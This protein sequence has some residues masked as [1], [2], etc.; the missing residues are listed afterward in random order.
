M[1]QKRMITILP[2]IL[3]TLVFTQTHFTPVWSGFPLQPFAV[4]VDIA[5]VN[6]ETL[7]AGDEIGVFDGDLCVGAAIMVNEMLTT[8]S[9]FASLDNPETPESDGFTVGNPVAFRI[10]D[11]SNGLEITDPD[12]NFTAGTETFQPFGFCNVELAEIVIA[13]CTDP[14]A[15]NYNPDALVDDGSCIYEI[16]G[17]TD[18]EACN[19]DPEAN[20]DDGSCLYYDCAGECGG[21]A[22]EDDCGVCDDDPENDN[23]CLGCMDPIALNYDPASIYDDGSCD[24]PAMGDTNGDGTRNVLDIVIA[25]DVVLNPESYDFLFWMDL[26]SDSYINILDIVMLVDW[27]LYPELVG[28]TDPWAENYDPDAIYDDGSCISPTV[29]DIDGNE[30][31][32]MGIG[33]QLWMAENLKVTHYN[34]GDPIPTGHSNSQWVNLS[35]GAYAVYNNDPA[36][37]EVYGNLYNWYAVDDD[38]GICPE[39]FHVPS[40]E[41]WMELEMFLGMSYADAHDTGYWRGTDQGSQLAGNADLWSNGSLE[42]DPAFGSSGFIA[43]PGGYRDFSNGSYDDVGSH[44][45]FWSATANGSTDAWARLLYYTNTEVYRDYNYQ[46]YGFPVRCLGDN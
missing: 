32:L 5:T 36:N 31:I 41:E 25:V 19:Y 46:R 42:N 35:T 23:A 29:T 1:F 40:D 44:G 17:C 24:Y 21:S 2:V 7:Q 33:D 27:V 15:I 39:G 26:N 34:N 20:T 9:I 6:G 11:D 37:A 18:P 10:W 14:E 22:Y 43:L 38:R 28:C 4:Y 12:V 8:V 16:P 45:Y 3:T 30:Y 13:G